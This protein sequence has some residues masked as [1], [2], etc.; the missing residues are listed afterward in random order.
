MLSNLNQALN[1]FK[2]SSTT[3]LTLVIY[4]NQIVKTFFNISI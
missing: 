1:I 4:H 3:Q 2:I